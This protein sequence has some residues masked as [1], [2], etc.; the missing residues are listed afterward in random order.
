MM[1]TAAD[2]LVFFGAT[3]DLAY[4]KIFPAL[5][6]I[7]KRGQLN[8][9][10]IAVAKSGWTLEQLHRRA[11]ESIE[12]YGR[13]DPDA[14][15]TLVRALSYI[16]G[17]YGDSATFTQLVQALGPSRRPVHY[18]AIPPKLFGR[19]FEQLGSSGASR[20]GRV[21]I[22]KPFGHDLRS[23]QALNRT[24]QEIFDE[25]HIFRIDHYL[26]KNAV[27]NILFFR[28]SNAF[29]EPIWN[30]QYVESVQIT[31]AES[32]GVD[33]RG[34]FYD[35]T[36]TI[37][38][39]VQNHLLQLLSNIAMEPPPGYDPDLFRDER[40]KVLKGIRPL[41]PQ[42]V[43]RGQFRGYLEEPGVKA[44][45]TVETFVAL[46]LSINSWRWKDVPFYIRA[47]K[48]LATTA[49]DVVVKLRQAPAVFTSV[50]PPANCFRFQVTPTQTIGLRSFVKVPGDEPRGRSVELIVSEQ[51]DPA[52]ISAYEDLLVD[53]IR[54]SSARF[55]RQDYVEE[56]WRIMDPVL[57]DAT[58]VHPYEPMSWG[59]QEADTIA[60]PGGWHN[61]MQQTEPSVQP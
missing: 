20:R 54:G 25:P 36:G 26:G 32:F 29:V 17:D 51:D 28:F 33:G 7:A 40:V 44:G 48:C 27:Q 22:E 46:R 19:V 14:F 2:A 10:V 61:P 35:Q 23:A 52:E 9:P 11:Q 60:P 37:R 4:K 5:Q 15:A 34:Q 1:S 30:R 31:M 45:S 41:L 6:A 8:I 24:V 12:R 47:G 55:A 16:D 21:I 59:P 18:L 39:V 49:T 43:V 13:F 57:D 42:D 56:A 3:G 38:D 53:A 50:A 58:P